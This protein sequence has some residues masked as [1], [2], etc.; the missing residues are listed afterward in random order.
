MLLHEY[1]GAIWTDL[2]SPPYYFITD[3]LDGLL[4]RARS[5]GLLAWSIPSPT[6]SLTHTRMFA[7]LKAKPEDYYFHR[8][9]ASAHLIVF[10]TPLIRNQASPPRAAITCHPLLFTV[11]RFFTKFRPEHS[12]RKG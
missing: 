5:V 4:K 3:E 9:V 11:V 10:N 12:L 1:Q 8:M 2:S 6:S 7:Y